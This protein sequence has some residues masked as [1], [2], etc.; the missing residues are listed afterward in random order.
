M[1]LGRR[2]GR[3]GRRVVAVDADVEGRGSILGS[4]IG[5]WI[6]GLVR[7]DLSPVVGRL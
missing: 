7:N 1:D 2:D 5:T 4:G 6:F 3:M